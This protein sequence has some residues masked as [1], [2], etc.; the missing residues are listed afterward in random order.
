MVNEW[1][2]IDCFYHK[3]WYTNQ[4]VTSYELRVI[5]LTSCAYCTSYDLLFI[6][7]VTSYL[8]HAS[9]E[10]QFIARVTSSCLHTSYKLVL[11]ARV[12]SYLLHASYELLFI[13][14]VTFLTF[15]F[16]NIIIG[17][18]VTCKKMAEWK[19]GYQREEK[20]H[21]LLSSKHTAF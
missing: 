6:V 2:L 9:Y 8:L 17:L 16:C 14:R 13:V 12:K 5:F 15:F 1:S 21:A 18:F 4:R 19:R 20:S 11:I 3:L 10:L 7:R